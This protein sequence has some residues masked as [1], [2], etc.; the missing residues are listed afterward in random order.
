MNPPLYS[1]KIE[2]SDRD[3]A[4]IVTLPEWAEQ[5]GLIGHTH[6]DTYVEAVKN[7]E[8]LLALLIE[9]R[10]ADGKPLPQ[11]RVFA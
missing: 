9:S 8:E 10:L 4:F 5:A 2:W 11:P 1:M 3:Q 7:G 6:G